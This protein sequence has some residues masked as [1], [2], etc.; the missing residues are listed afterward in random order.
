MRLGFVV[1]R[2]SG[3]DLRQKK[4]VEQVEHLLEDEDRMFLL[5]SPPSR[6]FAELKKGLRG[7]TCWIHEEDRKE[8]EH[9]LKGAC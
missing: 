9:H 1:D 5:S 2:E 7:R 6:G 4:L 8:V 3:W